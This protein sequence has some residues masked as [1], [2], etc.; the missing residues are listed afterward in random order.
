MPGFM[1]KTYYNL[2]AKCMYTCTCADNART[3]N[4]F[5]WASCL[6]MTRLD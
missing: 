3:W 1:S 2:Q 4:I 5:K 6:E